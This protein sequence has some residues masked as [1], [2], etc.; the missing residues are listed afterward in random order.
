[1]KEAV[2]FLFSLKIIAAIEERA[3]ENCH[4]IDAGAGRAIECRWVKNGV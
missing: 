4:A 1:M 3:Y 2:D